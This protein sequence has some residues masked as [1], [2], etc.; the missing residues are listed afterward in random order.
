MDNRSKVHPTLYTYGDSVIQKRTVETSTCHTVEQL[1]LRGDG[2]DRGCTLET[3]GR[4]EVPSSAGV[5]R[6]GQRVFV[7]RHTHDDG[8]RADQRCAIRGRSCGLLGSK[9]VRGPV[10]AGVQ[11]VL[12]GGPEE[13]VHLIGEVVGYAQWEGARDAANLDAV[14]QV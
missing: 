2:V 1:L 7:D 8:V 11:L 12:N 13:G 9:Y 6:A 5:P 14:G 4:G 3:V 10:D